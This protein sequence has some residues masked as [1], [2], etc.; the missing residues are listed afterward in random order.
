MAYIFDTNTLL[1][2][3]NRYYAFD[4]CPGFWDWLLV[5]KERGNVLCIEAVKNELEDPDAEAWAKANPTFFD[6]NDD[7]RM[8]DVSQWVMAQGRFFAAAKTEFLSKADP[9]V[10]SFALAKGHTVVTQ[11][12]SAPNSKK[13]VKIPD[14]CIAFGAPCK[15]SFQILNELNA[16]FILEVQP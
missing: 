7:S 13:A 11:E 2:A 4:V 16:R 10:I 14:V 8:A 3:K 5:E 6:A 1:E 9:R 12:V 15:N